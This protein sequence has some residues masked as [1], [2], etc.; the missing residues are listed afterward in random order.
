VTNRSLAQSYRKKA[1][2]R[3]EL[4]D[5]LERKSAWSDVV[6]EAQEIVELALKDILR[7]AGIEPPKWHD[8]GDILVE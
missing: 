1:E 8:V 3:L 7:D 6:R 4:L 5:V 2:D